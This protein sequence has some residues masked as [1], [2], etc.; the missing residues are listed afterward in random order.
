MKTQVKNQLRVKLYIMILPL[1]IMV[2]TISGYL[3]TIESR[4]A[5]IQLANRHLTFKAEQLRD[6]IY[7][8][9]GIV[10]KLQ[11]SGN[12]EYRSAAE[13][14]F[15][16]YSYSLLREKS[17]QILIFDHEGLLLSRIGIASSIVT[18]EDERTEIPSVVPRAGWFASKLFGED[19]VG[20]SFEFAP[21]GWIVAVTENQSQ[22]FSA[23]TNIIYTHMAILFFSILI[24]GFFTGV[25]VRT[26]IGPVERLAE[27]V[28]SIT[29]TGDLSRRVQM[30]Y[31]DEIGKL[32]YQTNNMLEFLQLQQTNLEKSSKAEIK[33][34]ETAVQ[35]EKETLMIL[36]KLSDFRDETTGAHLS[37]IGSLSVLLAGLLGHTDE[38][39][40][41]ILNS[42][43]LHDVGKIEIHDSILKKPDKLTT[44]EFE[45][46]KNH[47]IIGYQLLKNSQSKYLLEGA[48]IAY[49]HHE[50]WDGNGYPRG[51]SG[52]D[53]PLSG[54]IVSIVDVF[55]ALVSKRPYK[56]AWS[57]EAACDYIVSQGGTQFDPVLADIFGKNLPLFCTPN[58]RSNKSDHLN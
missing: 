35:R 16:S 24:V 1:V 6:F 25:Y 56:D 13:T 34:H 15:R 5:L 31:R 38:Q 46:I 36:G 41:L 28:E 51:L 27:T 49:T 54:R 47:T 4:S 7:S 43:P 53:I 50:R 11:L 48:I 32:A 3:S 10:E 9:W 23:S 39:K 30:E 22:F 18:T 8:E 52:E 58:A 42:S 26:I 17:E 55:D 29:Q 57:I 19:R 12:P 20:V 37:R 33:A 2:V 40:D 44:E 14:S 45:I 21:F